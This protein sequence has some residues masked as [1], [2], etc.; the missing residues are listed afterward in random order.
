MDLYRRPV[1]HEEFRNEIEIKR[2]RFITVIRRATTEQEARDVINELKNEFP[3]ARHH[4]SAFI[5]HVDDAVPVERSSDDGEPSGT[6]GTPMLDVVR[7]SGLLDIVAV[8]VRYF[9]GVKLGAGG[10]VHAY[11]DSVSQCLELVHSVQ[12]RR[13]EL[14]T[15][16]ANHSDAGRLESELRRRDV[17]IVDV[18]Y[19]NRVTMTIA[20]EIGQREQTQGLL[21]SLTSGAAVLREAGVSWIE[22]VS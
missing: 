17:D 13:R 16:E 1:A 7:G 22:S 3:D 20:V 2:S 8:V 6:A 18:S 21:S 19:S 5:V 12:R 14:Y 11:S 15:I 4:C 10:L 9:G